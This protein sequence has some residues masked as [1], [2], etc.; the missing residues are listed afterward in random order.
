VLKLS[1]FLAPQLTASIPMGDSFAPLSLFPDFTDWPG[2]ASGAPDGPVT[3]TVT[4]N[5]PGGMFTVPATDVTPGHPGVNAGTAWQAL[6]DEDTTAVNPFV[7]Q[8]YS[9]RTVHSFPVNQ[10]ADFV[11]S[12]YG[13]IGSISPTDP[14]LLNATLSPGDND[15]G[16]F[17]ASDPTAQKIYEELGGLFPEGRKGDTVNGDALPDLLSVPVSAFEQ[18]RAFHAPLPDLS[19]AIPE[20][21]TL[22]FHQGLTGLNNYPDIL[23]LLN[24]V[25]DLEVKVPTGTPDGDFTVLVTPTWSSRLGAASKDVTPWTA[26]TITSTVFLPTP[27]GPDYQ[28][29]M[30]GLNDTSRFSVTDL[31]TD[32]AADRLDSLSVALQTGQRSQLAQTFDSYLGDNPASTALTV[33]ALRSAGPQVIWTGYAGA[34][35]AGFSGLLDGQKNLQTSL[36]A[37]MA[38]PTPANLPVIYAEQLMRGHRFDVYTASEPSPTWRSLC[39]R[40]GRYVFGPSTAHPIVVRDD[41]EGTVSPGASQKAGSVAPPPTDLYV[42]ESIVRW[43]G[44]GLCAQRPGRQIDRYS[45]TTDPNPENVPPAPSTSGPSAP[46]LSAYFVPPTEAR[47]TLLFPKLR[48]GNQYQFR[49]RG[50]DLAG[51]SV[52]VTSTDASTATAPFTHYRHEPVRPPPS[53]GVA[54]FTPGEATLFLVLLDDQVDPPGTNGRWL[55]PPRVSELMAEEHGMFDGFSL[56]S[57]P[58]TSDGPSGSATTYQLITDY[59]AGNLGD[60]TVTPNDFSAPLIGTYDDGNQ[61][62]PYFTGTPQPWTPWLSDPLSA[63]PALSGLPGL[64]AGDVL[65]PVWNGVWPQLDPILVTLGGG[66]T[67]ASQYLA[68]TSG[69]PGTVEVTLPPAEVALVRISSALADGALGLLGVWQWFGASESSPLGTLANQGQVW[70]LSPFQV[71]R[72]VHAVRL[73][74]LAPAL[75]SPVASR[76][77]GSLSVD[78]ED[79]EFQVDAKSTSHVDVVAQWTDPYDNPLDPTSDPAE[80]PPGTSTM[81]STITSGGPAFRLTI[82]DPTPT[83]P[84]AQP[85]T[86]VQPEQ[87]FAFSPNEDDRTHQESTTHHVGD[88]LHHLIYY[89]ATGTSRFADLFEQTETTAM[90]VGTAVTLGTSSLGLNGASVQ[91]TIGSDTLQNGVD[92]SV[93]ESSRMVTLLATTA[94]PSGTYTAQIAYQPTVTV[95]GAPRA[96]EVLSTARPK[97]PVVSQVVP[98]WQL[99]GP[100]GAIDSG[101]ISV[102]RSGGFLRVYL[103]RPWFTSGAGEL[104]GVVT[105]VTS[106][107]DSFSSTFPTLPQQSWVTMMGIDP[108]NYVGASTTPWPVVPNA[109]ANLAVMPEV[110]YRPPYANPPQVHLAEDG[111]GFYQVW[112]YQVAYDGGSQRWYADIA[113]RPGETQ[114]GTYPPPPGYFIRLALVR[115]QPYS[116]PVGG[117][118]GGTVEVSPVVTATFAQPVPDRSVSVVTD[119]ADKTG[120]TVTVTVSGPAYQGWRPP[121]DLG[122][123]GSIQYDADNLYAPSNPSIYGADIVETRGTQHTSTMVVE[124]QIQNEVLNKLGI[125]GDLA[126]QTTSTG[127]VLLPPTFSGEVFVTWGG[128]GPGGGGAV[129]LP[130]PVTSATKMRLRISEIDYYAD[131]VAPAAVDTTFRRPFVTLIP[132]N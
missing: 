71:M 21:P 42:H 16:Y 129:V 102:T 7:F 95:T 117:I 83:G 48:F 69:S 29:G 92:F 1:V 14:I 108:I 57:P 93:E 43:H 103:E 94:R 86:V 5:G 31:D 128:T 22:D 38:A 44:W 82:P 132:L 34:D 62:V 107:S 111:E 35:F 105:T 64:A 13:T 56:G 66:T 79:P 119:S 87:P 28:N 121:A 58:T 110:P 113:P 104:L 84:E 70:L 106:P 4:F 85:L 115:F 89:T 98:A 36:T 80:P 23:R 59:D 37:W 67:P 2:S 8:D 41:D 15:N 114:E 130:E 131:D 97:V 63:G 61:G 65:T 125:E 6:F 39:G 53:A 120:K 96:V 100:S 24:L 99:E 17:S 55:F 74:L 40:R 3:F 124:V 52:D 73:P 45:N 77:P 78:I 20:T 90:T 49:A 123:Q 51:N 9:A 126:W 50:V 112:P 118:V 32:L 60:V 75:G 68:P 33:P 76:N 18:V 72:M 88:T 127:P 10:I 12:I 81:R 27:Q 11:S 25:F 47:P 54:P 101:G 19:Y 122:G 116:I 26:A 91:V 30:L 46:Q 109:F